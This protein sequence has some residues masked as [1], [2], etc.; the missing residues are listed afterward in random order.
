MSRES[1]LPA[2]IA[3]AE[4]AIQ[5]FASHSATSCGDLDSVAGDSSTHTSYFDDEIRLHGL[6]AAGLK[7]R[8]G[9]ISNVSESSGRYWVLLHGDTKLRQYRL[10]TLCLTISTRTTCG[11]DVTNSLT[12]IRCQRAPAVSP[13]RSLT[14]AKFLDFLPTAE[15]ERDKYIYIH[16]YEYMF[17]V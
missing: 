9:T 1:S 13:L 16:V 15:K 12:C 2:E 3:H 4:E 17:F 6:K 14:G 11:R 10:R 8:C 5:L 7:G